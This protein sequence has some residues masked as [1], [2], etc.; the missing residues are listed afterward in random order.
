MTSTGLQ[1]VHVVVGPPL[2]RWLR[3]EVTGRGNVPGS[4]GVLLAANHRSFLDH[5]ALAAACPRPMRFL[6]KSELAT[7]LGGRFNRLMGMVPVER[8]R[9]DLGAL[10]VVTDLLRRG[11][12]VGMFPEG[13]RSTTGELFRFR[14]GLARIAGA[15]GVPV[16]PVGLLG[17][18]DAWPRGRGLPAGRPARGLLTVRFGEIIEP[19]TTAPRSRKAFTATC[20]QRIAEL[21]CQDLADAFAPIEPG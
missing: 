10:D 9:A 13:T 21:C 7:G 6:G 4:G 18:A 2:R 8:G 14:S 3:L 12:V 16:V 11:E 1:A 15:A 20:R 17:M 5:F 19:P